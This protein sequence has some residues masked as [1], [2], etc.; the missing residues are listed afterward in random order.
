V[1]ALA[2]LL[3][4]Y[5]SFLIRHA[6]HGVGGADSSG[7]INTARRMRAG[8]LV[9]RP[10][11]LNRLGLPD[12]LAQIFIPLGFLTG[13]R[14]GTMAP[15]YPP[16]FPAHLLAAAT[17]AGW[18]AG[19]F[20]VS[21]LA[22][23]LSVLL[24]YLLGRDLGLPRLA[25]AA[26]AAILAAWPVFLFQALQPMSDV[27]ATLWGIAAIFCARRARD[28]TAWA[29]ASGAAFGVAVLVRPT[30]AVLALPLAFALPLRA[31]T[32]ALFAVGGVPFAGLFAAYNLSCYGSIFNSGYG[33]TGHFGA[34]ALSN[35]LPQIRYYTLQVFQTL[36]PL[37]PLAWLAVP[38][39]RCTD[40]RDRALLVTWFGAFL[41]L[42]SFY[43]PY[44][45]FI[46]V[47]FLLPGTPALVLGAALVARRVLPGSP[48]QRVALATIVCLA[49]L[50]LEV[51]SARRIGV[52]RIIEDQSIY[53][54]ACL[55]ADQVIPRRSVALS[56]QVSGSLEYYTDVTYARW[57]FFQPES[58]ARF[59]GRIE[60]AG[61]RLT[62]LL[63]PFEEEELLKHA[64]GH[65]KKVA[66]LREV[67]LWELPP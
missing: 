14:P 3:V 11:G 46:F 65:W 52:L 63:F 58:F 8:T 27:V 32:L 4:G 35:F 38:A 15:L 54:Q 9:E 22:A 16:G 30:I 31:P 2:A 64:P 34:F 53:P 24:L 45:S 49:V 43:G 37:V 40:S 36:S 7:Y 29:L 6:S 12:D 41:L 19:P 13:P 44:E 39:D 17:L 56:M 5:G 23:A 60:A 42:F 62:A 18:S 20:L 25:C 61:Y 55:W 51:S 59:R 10:R 50:A 48:G 28:R 1:V 67:A 47:R 33:K 26:A 57:D 66:T 21:P